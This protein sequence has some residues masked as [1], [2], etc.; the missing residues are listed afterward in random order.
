MDRDQI[1]KDKE[2]AR[3]AIKGL[4]LYAGQ[5]ACQ[6]NLEEVSH[7]R[8]IVDEMCVYWGVDGQRDWISEFDQKIQEAIRGNAGSPK[9]SSILRI[10][11][12]KGLCR[13]AEEMAQV[14]GADEIGRIL[15]VAEIARRMGEAWELP[16]GEIERI[17][18]GITEMAEALW[19]ASQHNGMG[20]LQ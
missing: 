18:Q 10:K 3:A 20:L 11:A 4:T 2:L 9:H 1:R 8:R 7:A 14:Q 15:E 13:Y 5:A 19:E 16:E 17:S 6:G 12:F